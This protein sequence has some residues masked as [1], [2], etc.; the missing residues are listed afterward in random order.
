MNEE[1]SLSEKVNNKKKEAVPKSFE[2]SEVEISSEEII[3][4][5]NEV[6]EQ[7]GQ[8]TKGFLS[9]GEEMIESIVEDIGLS[10]EEVGDIREEKRVDEKLKGVEEGAQQILSEAML[11]I[12]TV[13][14]ELKQRGVEEI[15]EIEEDGETLKKEARFL[16]DLERMGFLDLEY[17]FELKFLEEYKR[18]KSKYIKMFAEAS[19]IPGENE[20]PDSFIMRQI[21][22]DS[23]EDMK[24]YVGEEGKKALERFQESDF[25]EDP[26]SLLEGQEVL[27]AILDKNN[28][29]YT[30]EEG[31][32][33]SMSTYINQYYKQ[34]GIDCRIEFDFIDDKIKEDLARKTLAEKFEEEGIDR[35]LAFNKA[36]ILLNLKEKGIED[37]LHILKNKDKIPHLILKTKDNKI[38]KI[39]I[40]TGPSSYHSLIEE[41]N[42]I[43]INVQHSSDYNRNISKIL[44]LL[45]HEI[46]H[47]VSPEQEVLP[48][49]SAE[50][51]V[52]DFVDKQTE[53]SGCDYTNIFRQLAM[54]YSVGKK[55]KEAISEKRPQYAAESII[56]EACYEKWGREICDEIFY[57]DNYKL[58]EE[59]IGDVN[60]VME[61][62]NEKLKEQQKT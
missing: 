31:W 50:M 29:S 26:L 30:I 3:E 7:M 6:T 60:E 53:I 33:S 24:R 40:T 45:I 56:V 16:E 9:E 34:R 44:C 20:D 38:R 59:K 32:Q 41:E 14:N 10:P 4:H 21:D 46:R 1:L 62:V 42:F 5:T 57:K 55:E 61:M 19:K 11:D 49:G 12:G 37:V 25:I 51:A 8:A 43:K 39:S 17:L 27:N 47:A 36:Y 54:R 2:R 22:K 52:K 23:I 28:F 18:I 48:E 13:V 58:L 15:V 35:R